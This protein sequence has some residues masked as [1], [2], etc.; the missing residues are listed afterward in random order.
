MGNVSLNNCTITAP[1]S[2]NWGILSLNNCSVDVGEDNYFLDNYGTLYISEDTTIIGK[3]ES[4]NGEIIQ[5][6]PHKH[7]LLTIE[8]H[9][10]YLTLIQDI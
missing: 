4:T 10:K 3:I 8:Q 9:H 7:M 1:D 2:Q 5:E 6:E